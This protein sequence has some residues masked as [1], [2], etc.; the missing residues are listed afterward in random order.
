M[1]VNDINILDKLSIIS[2]ELKVNKAI[3]L[4][5][6]PLISSPILIGF[7]RP[8]IVLPSINISEIDLHYTLM[9]ELVHYKRYDIFY[10]W[11]L[12]FTVSL[13]WFNPF[14]YLMQ[15]EIINLCELSCDEIVISKLNSK[16]IK[17]YGNTLINA[18]NMAGNYKENL[19]SIN[20]SKNKKLLKERLDAIMKYKKETKT[21]L[22]FSVIFSIFILLCAILIGAYPIKAKTTD[23]NENKK[24]N[25]SQRYSA[26]PEAYIGIKSIDNHWACSTSIDGNTYQ[27]QLDNKLD[28]I[29][30]IYEQEKQMFI[31]EEGISL[32]E[33]TNTDGIKYMYDNSA[34]YRNLITPQNILY[35]A[36]E[37]DFS[38][39]A[40]D[41]QSVLYERHSFY[42]DEAKKLDLSMSYKLEEGKMAVWL[43][44]TDG[45]I[46]Y[47]TETKNNF[48]QTIKQPLDKGIYS[49]VVVYE[50][51][52]GNLK[53]HK[54]IQ[55]NFTNQNIF[56][57]SPNTDIVDIKAEN[58]PSLL[59][60]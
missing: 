10:K 52:N 13:H 51:D 44:S 25:F 43:V 29:K 60:I 49:I 19:F 59:H 35:I 26:N 48:E 12:Q 22:I 11:I 42:L 16:S 56:N 14:V 6:N 5:V 40:D 24:Y 57:K 33:V 32:D 34:I 28:Y 20:L 17:D 31:I 41:G 1:P 30:S 38:I 27:E 8:C 54:S 18:M 46:N 36:P 7:S 39:L 53:G 15:N 23:A 58:P 55:G 3:E 21:T 4:C 47:Q 45:K 50:M 9:H 2:Q 37:A